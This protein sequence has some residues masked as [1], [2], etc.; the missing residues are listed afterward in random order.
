MDDQLESGGA[1][2][3]H[4]PDA[5]RA[6]LASPTLGIQDATVR[7]LLELAHRA[8]AGLPTGGASLSA[9]NDAVDAINCGFDEC[10]QLVDCGTGQPVED[11]FND[12][13][14]QRP[15]LQNGGGAAAIGGMAGG[16]P[17]AET[18]NIRV[19]SSNYRATREPGEPDHAGQPGGKSLWWRWTAPRTGPVLLT[20]TGSSVDTLLAVYTGSALSGLQLVASNDDAGE[21]GSPMSELVFEAVAGVEYQIAVDSFERGVGT[22]VL[23]LIIERPRLGQPGF[24][25]AD[26]VRVAV[27]NGPVGDLYTVEGSLDLKRWR[28]IATV[29]N[30]DGTLLFSDPMSRTARYRFYRAALEFR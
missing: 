3:F 9:V 17:G 4:I 8:L 5:V 20:T 13:F 12:G 14:E 27:L 29:R 26:L 2:S 30:L 15:T 19:R 16:I 21:E 11:S 18:V 10:R 28:P 25:G 22:I 24:E 7:G 6:A 23:S 1:L